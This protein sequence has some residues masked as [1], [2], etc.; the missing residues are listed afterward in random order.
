MGVTRK[1]T[2][3]E[4]KQAQQNVCDAVSES[5]TNTVSGHPDTASPVVS[6]VSIM[7]FNDGNVTTRISGLVAK[8]TLMGALTE[9]ILSLHEL[10][11][12]QNDAAIHASVTALAEKATTKRRTDN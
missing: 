6:C 11:K 2:D 8:V 10:E 5:L 3:A 12:F 4:I 7:V 9:S 1:A